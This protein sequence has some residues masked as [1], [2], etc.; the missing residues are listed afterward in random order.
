MEPQELI[1]HRLLD[2]NGDNVG[3]IGH[4]LYDDVS[5]DAKWVTVRTGLFGTRECFV[6]LQGARPAAEDLQVPYDK[7]VVKDAPHFEA[8]QHISPEE[9]NEIY[10][11]YGLDITGAGRT[12]EQERTAQT[13]PAA[14]RTSEDEA[15]MTRSEEQADI[16]VRREQTGTAH[17]RKTVDSE[18]FSET[19]PVTH[20]R[21]RVEREPVTEADAGAQAVGPEEKE[22]T[23]YE[24]RP[25]VSK[26]TE[27]VE[28]I[29]VSKEQVTEDQEVRGEVRK[30]HFEMDEDDEGRHRR[31][32]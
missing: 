32:E 14:T 25:V 24:D 19:V 5:H 20:E 26:K 16:G 23:L 11:H 4:V 27:P 28:K 31:R 15:T 13:G 3:K 29:R 7:Q 30:E 8:D 21:M 17:V 22:F 18:G 6:P 12:Q 10:R 1:G 9:E 2:A